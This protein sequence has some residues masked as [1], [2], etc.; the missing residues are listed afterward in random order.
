LLTQVAGRA[1]RGYLPGRVL[2][3]TY[4]P[5]HYALKFACDQDFEGFFAEE[6]KFRRR[7]HYPPFVVLASILI[8]HVDYSVADKNAQILRSA[9]DRAN[10]NRTCQVLGPASASIA[11]LK[12]EFRLQILVKSLSRA[13]LRECLDIAAADAESKG[14]DLRCIHIEIDPVNLL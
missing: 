9:L 10:A 11:R 12:N 7:L 5:E 8:K 2:I 13:D 1:G 14:A 4:Y 6:I 3:Q